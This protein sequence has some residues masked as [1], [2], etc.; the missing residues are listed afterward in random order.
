[1]FCI[2]WIVFNFLGIA[3]DIAATAVYMI[4]Y[5]KLLHD[6]KFILELLAV[7]NHSVFA[8]IIKNKQEIVHFPALQVTMLAFSTTSKLYLPAVLLLVFGVLS[9]KSMYNVVI[10]NE[11][12]Q[13]R[14]RLRET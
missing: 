10:E 8:E 14:L 12:I 9:I 3:L 6:F 1:M 13:T 2:P 5:F 4:D 11:I 7:K